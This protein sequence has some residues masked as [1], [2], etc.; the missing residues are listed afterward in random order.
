MSILPEAI[1]YLYN[2]TVQH[3]QQN[4]SETPQK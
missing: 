2:K 1:F 3:S 4:I